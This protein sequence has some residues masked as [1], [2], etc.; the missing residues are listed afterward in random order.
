MVQ[1]INKKTFLKI[2]VKKLF[3]IKDYS[4]INKGTY[5]ILVMVFITKKYL[6]KNRSKVGSIWAIAP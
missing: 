1:K 2:I 6:F 5:K 4:P 3:T